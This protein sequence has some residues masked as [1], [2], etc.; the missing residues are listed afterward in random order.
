M[1]GGGKRRE[2]E[3]RRDREI[4]SES[5][6]ISTRRLCRNYID[7]RAK[8]VSEGRTIGE[9][10]YIYHVYRDQCGC[11]RKFIIVKGRSPGANKSNKRVTAICARALAR[12]RVQY[13]NQLYHRLIVHP[14]SNE[15]TTLSQGE[16]LNTRAENS[17]KIGRRA[18]PFPATHS[19][20]SRTSACQY[21]GQHSPQKLPVRHT[22]SKQT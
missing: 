10:I 15:L 8:Y 21:F 6:I 13:S 14:S 11:A 2:K 7:R 4:S 5:R 19:S 1:R 3:R 22:R 18:S 12:S 17:R 20:T 9:Y 16:I